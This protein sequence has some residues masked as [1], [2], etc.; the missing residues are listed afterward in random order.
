MRADLRRIIP[1]TLLPLA[2]IATALGGGLWLRTFPADVMAG[3][4][5]GA[6]VISVLLPV[7]VTALFTTRL[8]VT[9]ILDLVALVLYQLLVVLRD[10]SGL[11]ELA[12]GLLHGPSQLLTY[13]LPLV[14]PRS[15]LVA[16][17]ALT[18][19]CGAIAG[20]CLGRDWR[21]VV[22]YVAWLTGFGLSYAGSVRGVT[23]AT[24]GRRV[25][26]LV[27]AGLL[28][29]LLV[30]RAAQTWTEQD[31]AAA[32]ADA[33]ARLPARGFVSGVTVAVVLAAAA[34]VAVQASAFHG[35]PTT[36][37]RSPTVHGDQPVTPLAFIADLRS[38]P[39]S[40]LFHVGLQG[41]ATP[42][43]L[44]I[45]T[46]DTYDGDTWS[47][48][49][50]FRPSGGVIPADTDP[51]LRGGT[52]VRLS[53]SG[54]SPRLDGSRWMP[55]FTRPDRV[56]G[57]AVDVDPAS[58]MI[59]PAQPLSS[60][61]SYRVDSV[62][63][64][65]SFTALRPDVL[66]ATST[67]PVDRD[68]PGQIRTELQQI[69]GSLATETGADRGRAIAFLQAVAADLHDH[70]SLTPPVT[71]TTPSGSPSVSSGS[72]SSA[73]PSLPAGARTGGTSFR[74]VLESIL[75]TARE[76]TPEQ[77]ATLMALLARQVGVPARIATGFRLGPDRTVVR[78][79]DAW[80]WVE[81]PVAGHGWTVLDAAPDTVA[82]TRPPQSVGVESSSSSSPSSSSAPNATITTAN[83][84]GNAVAPPGRVTERH[85]GAPL[86]VLTV[87]LLVIALLALVLVLVL[88]LRKRWRA[89][90]RRRV[91][92]PRASLLGAWHET[93]DVLVEA[94]LDEPDAW[95]N[96]E[97]AVAAERRFG[98]RVGARVASLGD[99]ANAA[100]F[101]PSTAV[102]SA[103]A[104]AVWSEH[105]LLRT[106]VQ[107][108]LGWRTRL[109]V[110][111]RYHRLD[112]DPTL[113]TPASWSD[114]TDVVRTR[115]RRRR[116]TGTGVRRH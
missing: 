96:H 106:E 63:P 2:V 4:L 34:A 36:P 77:Y 31:A 14:S 70:Y 78:G 18:W 54:I 85:S 74:D 80:T 66:P 25:D 110:A 111:T 67:P 91:D 103:D 88:L 53:V 101:A 87:V 45:A 24:T 19:V 95:T 7:A 27:G 98:A 51:T 83:T 16:P 49:R 115:R 26:T 62:V 90:R 59:V 105:W 35:P 28:V 48:D 108:T 99:S 11:H 20:E 37:Q 12:S 32:P 33:A 39:S 17:V 76:G 71:A 3:P 6:A 109:V 72:A 57:I 75:G 23:D 29:V 69:V 58:G 1:W 81:V 50:V 89:S 61:V 97:I 79:Q 55:F 113:V 84:S 60:G 114:R 73:T 21:T 5:F 100:I 104:A 9:T 52:Q 107:H 116:N 46:L 65:R 44:P 93:I 13:A 102:T 94:G 82:G 92:D 68:V 42:G 10:P 40:R 15:L 86:S 43:Y 56:I 41:G 112:V 30:I 38:D 64:S 47:F 8:W 22:P